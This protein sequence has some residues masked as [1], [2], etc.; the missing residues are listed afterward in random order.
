MKA[1]DYFSPSTVEEASQLLTRYGEEAKLMAGG[2]DLLV[3]MKNMEVN[4]KYV[5]DLKRVPGLNRIDYDGGHLRIGALTTIHEI[6]V[7]P[8]IK[9]D[10][11][12]LAE[13][14]SVLGSV[15]I[16]DKGTIGG[17]LCH[18]SPSADLAPPLIALNAEVKIKGKKGERIEKLE[19]FFK[20]PGMSVLNSD[21]ILTEIQI[22][23]PPPNTGGVYLKF[24]PRKAMDLAVVGV[25]TMITLNPSNSV[26]TQAKIVLGAVAPTP[27]RAR[28]LRKYWKGKKIEKALVHEASNLAAEESKPISDIRGS[29][30]Y[31]K[32]II[33]VLVERGIAQALEKIRTLIL[34]SVRS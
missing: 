16:R 25:A 18:A 24:S 33:K 12:I 19:I 21:E 30:W 1:F 8:L 10:F 32:E 17:N 26:C 22:P 34:R 5:I 3:G 27:L 2:T 11:G 7:S 4:P 15:Q 29:A 23:T 14:A 28:K 31:R 6:E 9:K 20:G 13:A